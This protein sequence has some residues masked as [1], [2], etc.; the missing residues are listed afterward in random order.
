MAHKDE[1]AA[2][3]KQVLLNRS[4]YADAKDDDAAKAI[5]YAMNSVYLSKLGRVD[6]GN[7]GNP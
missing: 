7:N 2:N 5:A 3:G 1:Y 4:H 6:R